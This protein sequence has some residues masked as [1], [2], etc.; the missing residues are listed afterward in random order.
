M[1]NRPKLNYSVYKNRS[2]GLFY[3]YF[4]F[5]INPADKRKFGPYPTRKAANI[6]MKEE[7]TSYL[8][9]SIEGEFRANVME[10]E[11][12]KAA[13]NCINTVCFD[14]IYKD[15][16]LPVFPTEEAAGADIYAVVDGEDI[17]HPGQRKLIKTGLTIAN[18]DKEF[19]LQIQPRSALALKHGITV[20]NSPST[21]D[22]DYR[23]EIG[24]ILFNAGDAPFV[25]K[26]GD[27]IA[28]IVP[29]KRY[30]IFF[31]FNEKYR[32]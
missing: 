22:P 5:G 12:K 11:L 20:L 15:T 1:Q 6:A 29:T 30:R 27:R 26:T 23:G 2:D 21:I 19:E 17:I 8:V 18:M 24:V 31:V 7:V 3:A 9:K 28:Q 10:N 16:R 25:V 32:E 4:T 13:S 14:K